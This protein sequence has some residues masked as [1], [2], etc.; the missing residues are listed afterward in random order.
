MAD[1]IPSLPAGGA[2]SDDFSSDMALLNSGT[3]LVPVS[4]SVPAESDAGDSEEIGD[5]AAELTSESE[6]DS[7]TSESEPEQDDTTQQDRR[8]VTMHRRPTVQDIKAKYPDFF[9][10][11]PSMRHALFRE[12]EY[13][14]LF[15]TIDDAK[16]AATDSESFRHF[17]KL[18]MSGKVDDFAEFLKGIA[19]ANGLTAMATNFLPALY[20]TNKDMYFQVTIPVLAAALRGTYKAGQAANNNDLTNSALW[21]AQQVLG[22]AKFAT[23]ERLP[24]AITTPEKSAEVDTERQQFYKERYDINRVE[25][26]KSAASKLR[27]DIRKGLDP[28]GVFNEF[29]TN[30]LVEQILKETNDKLAIDTAHMGAMNSLWRRANDAGFVGNWK[31]RILSTYLSGARAVMP[32]IRTVTRN[33]A[34]DERRSQ[35]ANREKAASKSADRRDIT[36]SGQPPSRSNTKAPAAKEVNWRETSDLDFLNDKITMRK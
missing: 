8:V 3:E 22:D 26:L 17:R 6:E 21:V 24:A 18:S 15:P 20:K 9:T 5:H 31:D 13:V 16:E 23:G 35:V 30:L 1:I 29:T 19:E 7:E 10:D 2:P 25:I 28:N 34:L 32:G 33:L 4:D 36:G 11:F 27:A 14:S 12:K